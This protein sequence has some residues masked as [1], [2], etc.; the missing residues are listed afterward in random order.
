MKLRKILALGLALC[1]TVS[2][3]A[4]CTS[5]TSSSTSGESST[6][7]GESSTAESSAAS[8]ES[9]TE[10]S[11]TAETGFPE[12]AVE[13]GEITINLVQE[14][15]E[16]NTIT[17]TS[18]GSMNILR[19]IMDGLVMLNQNDEP[20]PA[21]AESWE[22]SNDG[23]TYTFK[24]RQDAKW[25]NGDPVTAKDF[26]FAWNQLFTA[27]T[28]ADYAS[29]WAGYIAGAEDMLNKGT[30]AEGVGYKAIDDYTLELNLAR[31]CTYILS[32]LAFPSFYPMNE[33][34]YTEI[35]GLDYYGK[36]ADAFVTNGAFKVESWAHESEFVIV[37]NPDYYDAENIKLGKVTYLMINDSASSYN[38]FLAGEMDMMALTADQVD[39]ATAEGME[40]QIGYYDDA[41]C[42]YLEFGISSNP[43]V[44]NVNIRKALTYAV[45]AE[46]F[47]NTLIKNGSGV[48]YSFT[49]PAVS[50]GEF[51][52]KVGKL[53][54]REGYAANDY[55]EAKKLLEEGL[56]ELNMT[57]DELKLTMIADDTSTS[58]KYCAF[59]QEQWKKNLG[60]QVEI[61]QMTYKQ[62]LERMSNHDF[63]IV[64]A[65]WGPDYNDPMT[66][67][68]LW[69]T[70]GGNNHP[71]YSNEEYDKLIESA[72]NDGNPETRTATLV[73]AEKII[74]DELPI[75]PVYNRSQAYITSER[76]H[77]VVRTGFDDMNLRWAY[78]TE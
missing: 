68:D 55:A 35:G 23:L 16:M 36:E 33:K 28:A 67:M 65:G 13:D 66:F 50:N 26:V 75:G 3:F 19:H 52:A 41:S 45:D 59:M 71:G 14:P 2:A 9:S 27:E 46:T 53:M 11:S 8:G 31:P 5:G 57:A 76:F 18:T 38:S 60:I 49:P 24:L 44:A 70:D 64:F 48:A 73:E 7:S 30:P 43:V 58:Q 15:P 4:G 22:I 34:A 42:W 37:K 69:V 56:K 74:I 12:N 40:A 20:V 17:T 32:I 1:L 25:T 72:N 6:A 29:T 54:D 77:G 62:R 10:E 21:I 63:D 39:Q 47:V 51:T 78:V 61:Q